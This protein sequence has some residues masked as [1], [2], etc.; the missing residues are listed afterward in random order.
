ME[1][2]YPGESWEQALSHEW[3]VTDGLG[4]YASGTVL[5][6]QTRRYHGVLVA[7]L[8]PPLGR[9]VLVSKLEEWLEVGGQSFPLSA[10]EFQDVTITPRGF[11]H[12]VGF[13][14]VEG[15]PVW[16]YEVAGQTLEKRV[17][18]ERGH[19]TTFIS[20]ALADGAA[21]LHLT[22]LC[23]FRDF[24]RETIGSDDW[25]FRVE[26][27]A[28][29]QLPGAAWAGLRVRAYGGATPYA[30]LFA[31]PAG[32]KW[33]YGREQGWWWHF[34]HRAER[35]RGLDYLED[36]YTA[37]TLSFDLPPGHTLLVAATIE[38]PADVAR[39]MAAVPLTPRP[40]LP[41]VGEGEQTH[42]GGASFPSPHRGR[43]A[44]GEGA[45]RVRPLYT[46]LTAWQ[47]GVRRMVA[48]FG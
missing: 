47:N 5:G 46:P 35:D 14:L 13:E 25:R 2:L 42:A 40:R 22:P 26:Q 20:Y 16:R 34:L 9:H 44:R 10:N 23:A 36:L 17:W 38:E 33:S 32:S 28:P 37:G 30:L 19:S 6:P 21:R 48:D 3:L 1:R 43:G 24:H 39:R 12:L 7:P 4:G 29:E 18:M 8:A 15:V 31:A 27:I 45:L 11:E 41:G